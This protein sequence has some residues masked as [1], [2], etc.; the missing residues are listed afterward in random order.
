MFNLIF[1]DLEEFYK[2]VCELFPYKEGKEYDFCKRLSKALDTYVDCLKE[3]NNEAIPEVSYICKKLKEI[4]RNSLGGLHT[5]AATQLKLL[6]L[7]QKGTTPKINL[8][9]TISIEIGNDFYRIRKL[10]SVYNVDAKELFHI[11][12][13]KRGIVKTQRY[14]IP[15]YPCLYLG[16]SI[17][18][19]WEELHR[20]HVYMC[21]VSRFQ[22]TKKLN[23]I[24]LSIPEKE[25][26][27]LPDTQKLIPLIIACMMPVSKDSDTY[28]PEYIV[29]QLVFELLIKNR[30]IGNTII[31]GIEYTSTHVNT[32]FDFSK[33]TFTNYAI[34]VVDI[35]GENQYCKEL[36]ST[37]QLTLPTT[38]EIEKLKNSYDVNGGTYDGKNIEQQKFHNYEISDFGCLE[39]RL[40][41][42]SKFP[43][44]TIF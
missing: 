34:P 43:L 28:K 24:N 5:T 38:N 2:K 20:P 30:K 4:V 3:Y 39:K 25:C 1:M 8:F 11:P 18:G 7:G 32:E 44:H 22:N 42:T 13:N 40:K 33:D 12:I 41:D 16:K 10:P 36:C 6:V 37:F 26:L 27:N 29:P 14:S 21:A 17:Y 19:C 35:N 9:K 23:L 31:H 15:G